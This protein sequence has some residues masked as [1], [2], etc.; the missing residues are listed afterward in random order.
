MESRNTRFELARI[1]HTRWKLGWWR[2]IF[3]NAD[4]YVC[5]VFVLLGHGVFAAWTRHM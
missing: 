1:I 4:A 3:V 5:E 2:K